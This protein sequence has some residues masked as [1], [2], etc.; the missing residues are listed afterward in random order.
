MP[1]SSPAPRDRRIPV[2]PVRSTIVFPSGATALQIGFEP[3]V[4]ALAV[5]VEGERTVAMV[6]SLD[7]ELP[8]DPRSLEKVGVRARVM[9][10]LNLPGGTIQATF[11]GLERVVLT[12]AREEDEGFYTAVARPAA[13]TPADPARARELIE[14]ILTTLNGVAARIDRI[15]DEVPRVLRMNLEDPGRFADLAANLANLKLKHRDAVLQALDVE[16]RLRVVLDFL[17]ETWRRI[18]EIDEEEGDGEPDAAPD[19]PNEIRRRIRALQARLGE[20]DPAEREANDLLRRVE[21]AH[22]PARVA[23]VARRETERLRNPSLSPSEAADLRGYVETLLDVPW[24]R[25]ETLEIDLQRVEREIRRESLGLDDAKQRLIEVLAVARLRGDLLGPIPCLVGPAGVGKRTLA[26]AIARGLGRPLARIE[27]GGRGESDLMGLRRGRSGAEPGKILQT[28]IDAGTRGP[29]LLLEE[30]DEIGL[31][32]VQGDPVEAMEE[33]LALENRERFEDRY[34]DVPLDLSEVFLIGSA[35]DF[36]RVPRDLRNLFVEVR[37]AGYTPEE[38]VEIAREWLFPRIVR[39]HGLDPAGV[40]VSD[41]TLL[42]LTRGYARDAGVVNLRRSLAAVMRYLARQRAGGEASEWEVTESL[43]EEVLGPPRYT[44]TPAEAAPEVGVVTGLAWTASGGELMFIE[45]LRMPG[46]GRLIITGLLGDVMRE[47]VNA[48]FSYVRSRSEELGIADEVFEKQ[49]I[50]VHFPVGATPKDG[51]S[52]GAAVTLAIAS[53]LSE[54]PVRH[55]LAMTG[56]VTL[57]GKILEVGGIKEKVLAAYRAGIHHVAMPTNNERD[58]RD[59]PDDVRGKMRFDFVDRM[60][61]IFSLALMELPHGHRSP[62]Q[63]AEAREDPRERRDEE[64][65]RAEVERH[66]IPDGR[67]RQAA[68]EA[69]RSG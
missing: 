6:A 7:D 34:L 55:D 50:H 67:D 20:E 65:E 64:D 54:R 62:R 59:V 41:E 57:R 44:I 60:D 13:E 15:P 38:K 16:E 61:Q 43:I 49:D 27:L 17:D 10:R 47:S 42:F 14:R 9:D 36:Y 11:Q 31:G 40:T 23:S 58:L 4:A 39:E 51:P 68:R 25:P 45:A 35:A 32:N 66:E 69:E 48:A 5:P 37:I 26:Q 2:L 19:D 63:E 21:R 29:V 3:N 56:E 18:R 8:I 33:V 22:L 46:S 30:L 28:L 12:D 53:S 1:D 52:A 24:E